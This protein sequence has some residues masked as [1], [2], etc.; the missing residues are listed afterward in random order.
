MENLVILGNT[1]NGEMAEMNDLIQLFLPS[2]GESQ[3]RQLD[4]RVYSHRYQ[5]QSFVYTTYKST[6][7]VLDDYDNFLYLDAIDIGTQS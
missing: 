5:M 4:K 3:F 6:I 1:Y 7:V 2:E